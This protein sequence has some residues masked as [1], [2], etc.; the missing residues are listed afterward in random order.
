MSILEIRSLKKRYKFGKRVLKKFNLNIN[1]GEIFC[2][3]GPNGAGKTT[4]LKAIIG[5]IS[6]GGEI[7]YN[8]NPINTKN[9][10]DNISFICEEEQI[11][12]NMNINNLLNLINSS[13]ISFNFERFNEH[14]NRFKIDKNEK[15]KKY[16]SGKKAILLLSIVL[17]K[18]SDI[19][20]LDEPTNNLDPIAVNYF[21]EEIR[22]MNYNNKTF[23]YTTHILSYAEK[24]SDRIGIISNGRIIATG[25]IDDLKNRYKCFVSKNKDLENYVYRKQVTDTQFI[26]IFDEQKNNNYDKLDSNMM[27]ENL[28]FEDIFE[29]FVGGEEID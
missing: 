8:N 7:L 21:T 9:I 19:Y 24:L 29:M 15:I 2:L 17:S 6:S 28:S 16:S 1:K 23:I 20:I 14:I 11:Y 12:K 26:Y 13:N 18:N 25:S 10:L 3:L 5:L 22:N 27:Q 4:T